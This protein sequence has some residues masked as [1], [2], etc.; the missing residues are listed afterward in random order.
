[1][2]LLRGLLAAVFLLVG[3][4]VR[5]AD[6]PVV[7]ALGDS[8]T[9]GE[10]PGV[11][12]NETFVALLEAKLKDKGIAVKLVNAG[13]G[14]ERT[15][16]GLSRLDKAVLAH[17][18]KVVLIMYGT[19][20]SYVDA[21]K[22][23]SRLSP[24]Q[25]RENLVKLVD[26]IRKSGSEPILMTEP[27]WAPEAKNGIG[28]N[29]NERLEKY[30]EECRAVAKDKKVK[31]VDHYAYWQKAETNGTKIRDWTTDGCH[32]NPQ[33]HREIADLIFPVLLDALA[34]GTEKVSFR[35]DHT[36]LVGGKPFF[37]IG[38]YYCGEEFED[39]SGKLLTQLRG[40]GFNTLGYYRWGTP[41][42]RKE[43]DRAHAA[44]FKVWIRGHDGFDLALP[45]AEK[46]A[47][48]QVRALRS[49]PALVFWEFQDEPILNKVSVE[50]SRKGYELVKKEDPNHPLLV[51]E[52]P[53]AADRF[54]L[55]KGIGDIVATDLYPIP[56][57]R[58]YGQLPNHDITQMRDYIAALRKGY[59]DK[60]VMLVLQA[61]AWE[62]LKDGEKG[63]PT[64]RESRFMAYQAV[65]HGAKGLYYYGQVHCTKPSSAA[66]ISSE[67]KDPAKAKKEFEECLRLNSL[68]WKSHKP[69]FQELEK[70]SAI[71]V[72]RDAKPVDT[73]MVLK[74]EPTGEHGIECLTKQG[75]KGLILLAVNADAKTRTATFRFPAAARDVKE[76]HVLFENRK[77]PVKDGEFT[78][79][80]EAYDTHVY[81]TM[82]EPR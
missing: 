4:Q 10:R 29:P 36:V 69:F 81:S 30:L 22:K 61:W 60:P 67:A 9:R 31:L 38:L 75:E 73:V 44:G 45:N 76:V 68:F 28:E 6:A 42:W 80:F 33:G 72:L 46:G 7:V 65:I 15:D 12:A 57:E 19:N 20:D 41:N 13:V 27:R 16:G 47:L 21:E 24:T 74:Q 40:Y 35:D 77:I 18:P 54:Q 51:V 64:V 2:T 14:G 34:P 55:W 82:P 37:P 26:A 56:R 49:H 50:G 66:A 52:W 3:V 17:A 53:G 8:I 39:E 63:Y 79:K 1:M 78:D 58:K 32:P 23:E 62:P 11:K 70:A 71:F 25:Y 5:A 59:G 48:E 43:L